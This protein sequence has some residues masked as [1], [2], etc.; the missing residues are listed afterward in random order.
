MDWLKDDGIFLPMINDTG[1]NI[2][3][4]AAIESSVK[5]KVVVDIGAGTGLLSIL[6]VKAGAK[7]VIAV[8]K[9]PGRYEFAKN[10]IKQLKLENQIEIICDD[11]LN[12]DIPADV[13]MSETIGNQIFNENILNLFTHCR[14]HNGIF[15]P[16][17]FEVCA[18]AYRRHPIFSVVET[19]SEA[20]EFQ[21]DIA[22]DNK[23]EDIINTEFQ[24]SH[25][26]STAKYRANTICNLFQ[27]YKKM[28]DLRLEELY[29]SDPLVIDLTEPIDGNL[30]IIVEKNKIPDRSAMIG[31]FWKAKFGQYTMNVTDTIWC[32]PCKRINN[33][34]KDIVVS[35]NSELDHWVFDY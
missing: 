21:P 27:Q 1:R 35:Y 15:I 30:S 19:N 5:D 32:I 34:T 12:L 11:F 6:A 22:I 4:K 13:Y 26:I 24:K 7:K 2:F 33:I 20:F 31:I 9:D 17:S 25:S 29:T 8:E 14:K 10:T 16:G 23:F 28:S 3:Y 18:V